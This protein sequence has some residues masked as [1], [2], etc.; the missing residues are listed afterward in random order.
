[1][2]VCFWIGLFLNILFYN[3]SIYYNLFRKGILL[4]YGIFYN[5][6]KAHNDIKKEGNLSYEVDPDI[7]ENTMIYTVYRFH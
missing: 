7:F 4:L 1:M 6:M 2:L 5:R 3:I